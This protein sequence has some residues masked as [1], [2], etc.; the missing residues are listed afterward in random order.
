MPEDILLIQLNHYTLELEV[1]VIIYN[2]GVYV[3]MLQQAI[4]FIIAMGS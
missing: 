2:D 3:G 1:S 4:R